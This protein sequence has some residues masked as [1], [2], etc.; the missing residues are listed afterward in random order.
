MLEMHP[1]PRRTTVERVSAIS[2][3]VTDVRGWGEVADP[4]ELRGT[5]LEPDTLHTPVTTK[6]CF[7]GKARPSSAL[8]ANPFPEVTDR[9]CR[10]P[11]PT[12][13]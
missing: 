12:C 5:L 9:V 1:P 13:V 7:A 8:R 6:Y 3:A 2:Q 11:L 4:F 10:L